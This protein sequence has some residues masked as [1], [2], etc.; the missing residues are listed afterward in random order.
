[1]VP[2]DHYISKIIIATENAK[3][4]H[5]ISRL[6][7]KERIKFEHIL[8]I[9]IEPKEDHREVMVITTQQEANQIPSKYFILSF[10]DGKYKIQEQNIEIFFHM[11]KTVLDTGDI[12]WN[13][14]TIGIDPGFKNTGFAFFL[15]NQIV[16]AVKVPSNK[17]RIK[18]Y[19]NRL[20]NSFLS[21]HEGEELPDTIIKIGSGNVVDLRKILNII[22]P[23]N[24]GNLFAI[25][26]V[27]EFHSN[28]DYII[29]ESNFI[30]LSSH[31][32]AAINIALRNG[33]PLEEYLNENG[34][35]PYQ[36]SKK[37]VR[38]M[39]HESRKLT[40]KQ[41]ENITIGKE[42]A[43][44]VLLGRMSLEKAIEIQMAKKE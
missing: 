33:V 16:E 41:S 34:K 43:T 23:L 29:E 24:E 9:E 8:P 38:K 5:F 7:R 2:H 31:A 42:L 28:K 10:D 44:K 36:F 19:I 15:N 1:M 37:Q 20:F 40:N 4:F 27:N 21:N 18:G 26:I 6:F 3:F 35:E 22:L 30:K 13:K 25:E 11:I 39:Q 32:R 17:Q 12:S 14:I